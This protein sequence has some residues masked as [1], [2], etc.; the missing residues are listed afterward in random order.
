[1]NAAEAHE[2]AARHAPVFA[3]KVSREWGWPIMSPQ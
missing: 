3:Q 1:M 2:I